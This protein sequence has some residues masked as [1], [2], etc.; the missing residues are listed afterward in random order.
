M[1]EKDVQVL[2]TTL[3]PQLI[4]KVSTSL[5]IG[6]GRQWRLFEGPFPNTRSPSSPVCIQLQLRKGTEWT[7]V[8]AFRPDGTDAR[9]CVAIYNRSTSQSI[10]SG[11]FTTL[12]FL[13]KETDTDNAVTTGTAWV[14]T[15]PVGKGGLYHVTSTVGFLN[16][17]VAS[18]RMITVRKNATEIQRGN[19][20][21]TNN[22]IMYVVVNAYIVCSPGDT[23][24]VQVFQDSG[25]AL[26]TEAFAGS[27]RVSIVRIPITI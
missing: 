9:A 10:N 26:N 20:I 7:T 24:D 16:V 19:R 8:V 5:G 4:Q 11:A 25:G 3:E 27:S 13:T 15:V 1:D 22:F 6:L 18:T 21:D 23:I 17:A 2:K 12:N 14:F